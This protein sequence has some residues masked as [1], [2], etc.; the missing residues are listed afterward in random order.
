MARSAGTPPP[1][2]RSRG[3]VPTHSRGNVARIKSGEDLSA[4]VDHHQ[5]VV[6]FRGWGGRGVQVVPGEGDHRLRPAPR[7]PLLGAASARAAF[8][9][10]ATTA[11]ASSAG[12]V[13]DTRVIP[14]PASLTVK[15]RD[16]S[17]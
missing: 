3:N 4:D 7:L 17:A 8:S 5:V 12:R 6:I 10:A 15:A 11:A 14:S 2:R 9:T 16:S 1:A 13:T